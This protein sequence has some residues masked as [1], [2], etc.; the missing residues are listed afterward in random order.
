MADRILSR[1]TEPSHGK[2]S[3]STAFPQ[4]TGR[5]IEILGL[6][7]LG[8]SNH[9]ISTRLYLSDKTVRNHVSNILAKTGAPDRHAAADMARQAGLGGDPST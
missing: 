2:A 9:A 7:A 1:L 5:E 8:L 3:T 4:L 6:L